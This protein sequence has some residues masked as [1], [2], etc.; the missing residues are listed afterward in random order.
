MRK[1][2][3]LACAVFAV[4]AVAAGCVAEPVPPLPPPPPQPGVIAAINEYR[5][6]AHLAPVV[7]NGA[8]SADALQH[9]RY[10]VYAGVIGHTED[11][12]NPYFT[13]EGAAAASRSNAAG[14][15]DATASDRSFVDGWMT[16]PFHAVGILDPRLTTVGFG[17]YRDAAAPIPAAAALN[18][19][20]GLDGPDA[21]GVVVFPGDGST[22]GITGYGREW[23]NALT[24]C[25]GYRFPAGL[26]LI[27]QLPAAEQIRT[28]RLSRQSED[29][30]LCTYDGSTY[31][32]PDPDAQQVGRD[33]LSR[34]DAT[35]LI[36]REPLEHGAQY[37][38]VVTTNL[39][40]VSWTFRVR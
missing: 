25:P 17:A 12:A 40:I 31:T 39:R 11:P 7:E 34:R 37:V 28:A 30:E 16:A 23:P 33:S 5:T 4:G 19:L 24:G 10:M 15:N 13:P 1:R 21:H 32:N 36:P 29:L 26:P 3:V 8:W 18:I 35:V 14:T 6:A 2:I 20:D 9:A 22:V 27:V 38:A